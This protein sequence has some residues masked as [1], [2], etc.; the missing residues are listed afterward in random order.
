[1]NQSTQ[2]TSTI[3][4]FTAVSALMITGCS[5][6]SSTPAP[7]DS[8]SP[9]VVKDAT[10]GSVTDLKNAAVISGLPCPK[11]KM[12]NKLTNAAQSAECSGDAVLATYATQADLQAQLKQYRAMATL[13]KQQSVP[14]NSLLIGPNW[15]INAPEAAELQP[16]LGGVVDDPLS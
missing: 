12:S 7:P 6:T 9:A 14:L 16:M 10:Y 8:T 13:F 1:M 15:T 2:A 5:S 11:F 4:A 3:A